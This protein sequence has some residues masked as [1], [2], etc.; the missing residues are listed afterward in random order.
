MFVVGNTFG[1]GGVTSG[2]VL[3]GVWLCVAGGVAGGFCGAPPACAA[4]ALAETNPSATRSTGWI[5]FFFNV[6]LIAFAIGRSLYG[7]NRK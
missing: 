5:Q 7:L 6:T 3:A 1:I 2:A 4:T